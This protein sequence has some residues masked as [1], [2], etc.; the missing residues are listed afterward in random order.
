MIPAMAWTRLFLSTLG[1]S[2]GSLKSGLYLDREHRLS[3]RTMIARGDTGNQNATQ[4]QRVFVTKAADDQAGMTTHCSPTHTQH[5][6][7]STLYTACH[8]AFQTVSN[9]SGQISTISGAENLCLVFMQICF[10][11]EETTTN[12]MYKLL[13]LLL[14]LLQQQQQLQL[15]FC[16]FFKTAISQSI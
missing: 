14:L 6:Y 15:Q 7:V 4:R 13:L 16:A 5:T 3:V 1:Q 12:K 2:E 8:E 11:N 10:K 9:K